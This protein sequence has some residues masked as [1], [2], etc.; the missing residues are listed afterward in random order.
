[1]KKN[2][3]EKSTNMRVFSKAATIWKWEKA[4]ISAAKNLRTWI[5]SILLGIEN[6][7]FIT[8]PPFLPNSDIELYCFGL[9]MTTETRYIVAYVL[10]FVNKFVCA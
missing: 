5:V 3:K 2:F 8:I 6:V 7:L 4:T 9:Y 10:F 1:M